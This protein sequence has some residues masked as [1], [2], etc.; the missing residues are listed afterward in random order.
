MTPELSQSMVGCIACVKL[1]DKDRELLGLNDASATAAQL[2][3][4]CLAAL[5]IEHIDVC[6]SGGFTF[7]ACMQDMHAGRSPCTA[8]HSAL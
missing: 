6:Y 5:S 3:C 7:D 2:C 8:A 4:M 1:G